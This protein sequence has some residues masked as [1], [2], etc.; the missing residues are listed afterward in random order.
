MILL[1]AALVAGDSW[2]WDVTL[3]YDSPADG[4]SMTEKERWTLRVGLRS[5][6]TAERKYLGSLVD[7]N[8]IPSADANPEIVKGSIERDGT[9]TLK[10]DWTDPGAARVF[11]RLL[12]PDKKMTDRLPGWSI[13][14]RAQIR[15]NEAKL[16]GSDL[17]TQLT[18]E[19]L[20]TSARLGGQEIKLSKGAESGP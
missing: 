18:V 14:R 4:F 13:V 5:A 1:A 10:P 9:L 17:P 8:L 2:S 3:R 7:G 12:N 20:L 11:R 16:P 19:A 15:E 6:L